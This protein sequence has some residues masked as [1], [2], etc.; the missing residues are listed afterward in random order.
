MG[1]PAQQ[2]LQQLDPSARGGVEAGVHTPH[3]HAL[4]PAAARRRSARS[5][6][7]GSRWRAG[8]GESPGRR[9]ARHVLHDRPPADLDRAAWGSRGCARAA[10]CRARRRG[11]RRVAGPGWAL[12]IVRA[13]GAATGPVSARASYPAARRG[14]P[15]ETHRARTLAQRGR[16]IQRRAREHLRGDVEVGVHGGDVVVLFE[17]RRSAS[18]ASR[19]GPRAR[20]A[21]GWRAGR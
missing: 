18:S 14:A 4:R 11:S 10:V 12:G 8:S 17:R 2:R 19:P 1:S 21:R 7:R 20:S 16:P 13:C 5:A 6:R 3:L 9:T 15:A